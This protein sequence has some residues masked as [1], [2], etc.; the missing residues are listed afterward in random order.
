MFP[1]L[2][3]VFARLMQHALQLSLCKQMWPCIGYGL[4]L[5]HYVD[6]LAE[7]KREEQISKMQSQHHF[8]V[9]S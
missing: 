6:T 3:E 1:N 5:L 7:I 9:Q 8:Q 4:T 2:H